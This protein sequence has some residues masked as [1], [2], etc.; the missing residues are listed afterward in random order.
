MLKGDRTFNNDV[1]DNGVEDT[2]GV[3][4]RWTMSRGLFVIALLIL[5]ALVFT[6]CNSQPQQPSPVTRSDVPAPLIVAAREG[7]A[8]VMRAL[9]SAGDADVNVR[10]ERG[11]TPLIEAARFGYDDTARALLERG[12]NFQLKNRDGQTALALAAQ[13][14]HADVVRML[15]EAGAKE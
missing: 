15:K 5:T 9:L 4:P 13:N 8:D 6:G 1:S 14:G 3:S 11:N 10:D 2:N 12:A 7:K